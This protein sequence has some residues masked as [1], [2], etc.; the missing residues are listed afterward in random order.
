MSLRI[1]LLGFVVALL[2]ASCSANET[3]A[4]T[5]AQTT[6][7]VTSDVATSTSQPPSPTAVVTDEA[8]VTNSEEAEG[9]SEETPVVNPTEMVAATETVSTP[10]EEPTEGTAED[11]VAVEGRTDDGA[12]FMGRVDAPLRMI[13]YSDFL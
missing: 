13:D 8:A 11:E 5:A 6:E 1:V 10:A 12:Y 2:V 3:V 9:P 7:P 4:P